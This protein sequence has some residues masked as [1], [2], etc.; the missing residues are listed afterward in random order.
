MVIQFIKMQATGNDFIVLDGIRQRIYLTP[1]VVRR[2]CNRHYGIGADGVI[3]V[4]KSTRPRVHFRM[5][6]FNADGS[7]PEMCGNGIRCLGK[8]VYEH[9][10][11]RKKKIA[12]ETL[13]GL[14]TLELLTK[15]NKVVQVRVG[16]GMPSAIMNDELRIMNKRFRITKVVLGNPHCVVFV[17]DVDKFPVPRYGLIIEKHRR[18]PHRTNVEFVEILNRR[19]I[20]QRTWERGVGETLSCGTGAVAAVAAGIF[21]RRLG[22]KVT[23]LLKGGRLK[24]EQNNQGLFHLTGP[25]EEVFD[26]RLRPVA[27][28]RQTTR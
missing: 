13:A 24:I 17:K 8:F 27:R 18:F 10:F 20:K 15:G 1:A 26:G 22:N 19:L 28:I 4:Q 23:V 16:M 12:V 14:K 11:T 2:L 5:R 7:E 21:N 9:G 6:I 25:V 3:L